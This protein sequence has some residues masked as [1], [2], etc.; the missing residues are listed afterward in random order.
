M[1]RNETISTPLDERDSAVLPQPALSAIQATTYSLPTRPTPGLGFGAA[2]TA[3]LLS[4]SVV[5]IAFLAYPSGYISDVIRTLLKWTPLIFLGPKGELGGFVLNVLVSL[6]AMSFGTLLGFLLGIGQL[7]HQQIVSLPSRWLTQLFRNSPWLVILFYFM[8]LLPYNFRIGGVEFA[9]PAWLKAALAF[10]LPIMANISEIVRGAVHS[11]P[12][13]QWEAAESLALTRAQ[14]MRMVILPQCIKRMI[15][16]LMNWYAILLMSTPLMSILGISEA[17]TL[18]R[19]A[20]AAENR[21]E[22]LVPM[23]LWLMLWF[24]LSCYP[25]ARLTVRLERRWSVVN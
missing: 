12:H 22:I 14:T 6:I 4:I 2:A 19:D 3:V 1:S 10:S 13:G 24:F 20:L 21:S 16:P 23:Y 5:I 7:S 17:M 11:I 8:L 15:P 18:T 25:I 9:V